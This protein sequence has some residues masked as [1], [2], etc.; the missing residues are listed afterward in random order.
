MHQI[1]VAMVYSS[2][3]EVLN[4]K[5]PFKGEYYFFQHAIFRNRN[6]EVERLDALHKIDVSI[7]EK[8]YDI[9]LLPQVDIASSMALTG[10]RACNIPVVA[11]GHDPHDVLKRDMFGLI[12]RLKVDRFF[13][14]YDPATFY[15]YYP[16]EFK[17]ETVHY[18]LEPSL[19]ESSAPWAERISDKI[20]ISGVIDEK[21]DIV[22]KLYYTA[23]LR[24]PKD[25]LPGFH[26][27]LRTKC[28]SLP[29]VVHT[30]D[31]Y[32]GQSTDQLH[33]VLSMFKAAIAATTSFPT[34]KYKETPAAGCLTF[35]EITERNHGSFLGFEDGKS[36]V[37]IDES[38]YK[39]KL[40]EYLDRPD[41]PRWEKI[42]QAGKRHVLDNLSND[43]GVKML[44]SIMRK[45]L[46]EEDE[47]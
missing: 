17:Y 34:M 32:P 19:C 2:G 27:K 37:F 42:V 33:G 44:V 5:N 10:I 41:D 35:M 24:K 47:I 1:K 7:L 16:R 6:L 4:G 39:E 23:Y 8:D 9:V 18:G 20:A 3:A 26:Y 28:N 38:N 15:E 40:Q 22:R 13:D 31:V 46:G 30:R 36:A 11:K 21:F 29:Y 14:F 45:A 12:H 43:Q 25:L